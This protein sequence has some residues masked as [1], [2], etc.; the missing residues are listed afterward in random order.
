MD[1]NL[2]VLSWSPVI[3]LTV[4]AVLLRRSALEL[5][6]YGFIFSLGLTLYFFKTPLDVA[7]MASLDG[8]LTSLPLLLVILTGIFLSSLLMATGSITRIV[9][10]FEHGAGDAFSRNI[11]IT[12]GVGNFMEGSGVIA[13][14]VVAPM[15]YEAQ[16]P[17]E[18]S[19]AL[20]IIGYSGMMTLELAGIIITV[21][22]L[23]TDLPLN[24]LGVAS[25]WLSIP[26]TLTMALCAFIFLPQEGERLRKLI[27]LVLIG[28]LLGIAGLVTAIFVGIH[29][30]GTVA[31][32]AVIGVLVFLGSG[33]LQMNRGILADL[34]PF[35][36]MLVCLFSVNMV[37]FLRVLTFEK[38]VFKVSVIPIH[39]ITFS[40]L[41]SAYVYLL[42]AFLV[43]ARIQ[44][45]P[46]EELKTIVR[47]SLK[48]GW[49]VFLAMGL[50]GAMGQMISYTGYNSGFSG[51]DTTYNI[52]AIISK[53][54]ILHSGDLYPVFV[55]VLGW[56]GTFL[57][58]YGV[59]SLMLFG[60]LQVQAATLL[61]VSA[62]WLA[63]GLAVGSSVGSIS[64]PFKVALATPMCGAIG[65]EGDILRWTIPLGFL[66]S[67]LV[68]IVLWLTV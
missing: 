53:G 7:L 55:P 26:A 17:P 64:S 30:S 57:T 1:G 32:I 61:G 42:I 10:W 38:L 43:S 29:I 18:G 59:A 8:V 63:A 68:G 54:L 62:T 58:G 60:Q 65:K 50:F 34:A 39:A 44:R 24:E 9:Q 25:A 47:L 20:S 36:I 27:T 14:P 49:R 67:L 15:L 51:L 12:F 21:L 46:P 13:E 6:V 2:F 11:L 31:G 23:V 33:R 35:I 37:P 52:P 56:V 28:L 22:S 45:V 66:S 40:P 48:K 3:F 16:V 4:M 19:A 41:F 5:S